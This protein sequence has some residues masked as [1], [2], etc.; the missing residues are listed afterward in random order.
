MTVGAVSR[1]AK[2]LRPLILS[3]LWG[4]AVNAL[5]GAK[6]APAGGSTADRPTSRTEE[7]L[8]L[9]QYEFAAGEGAQRAITR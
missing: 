2:L 5:C 8:Y 4:P 9:R 1:L 3:L 6:D 7:L